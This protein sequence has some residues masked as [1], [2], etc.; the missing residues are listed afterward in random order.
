MAA[1]KDLLPF[2]E[3]NAAIQDYIPD[4]AI[5]DTKFFNLY[6]VYQHALTYTLNNDERKLFRHYLNL[7]MWAQVSRYALKGL[8]RKPQK[9]L[10][11]T[12]IFDD[13]RKGNSQAGASPSRFFSKTLALAEREKLSL[14]Q[15]V[16]GDAKN[17]DL[18]LTD[19][20]SSGNLALDQLEV[21][22]LSEINR[23]AKEA[24]AI[25][26]QGFQEYLNAA[27]QLFFE[28]FHQY[29]AAFKGQ[30]IDRLFLIC[31][32]HNE[33][34]IA[35]CKI[36]G[37][38]VIEYQHGLI[39]KN[40]LYYVYPESII[41]HRERCLFPDKIVVF[42]P[43]WRD[44]LCLGNEFSPEQVIVG[45]NYS[46]APDLKPKSARH[47]KEKAILIGAQKNMADTYVAYIS[48]LQKRLAE[49]HPEWKLLV[50][51]HPSEPEV[52]KY[53]QFAQ[54]TNCE[55]HGKN[56]VLDVL[57]ERS[58]IQISIYSTT[59]YDAIG[60]DVLNLSLQN[61]SSSSDYAAEMVANK[62][63]FPLQF[64]DDP[65]ERY[66][67]L[68][69]RMGELLERDDLYAPF[70]ADVIAALINSTDPS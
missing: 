52:E 40:D 14:I 46:L 66:F 19:L 3:L 47:P 26:L 38:E 20:G 53:D 69:P 68:Q 67:E 35:A 32:Y 18:T 10:Q 58:L 33:S 29:Y 39:A 50:K 37:I 15:K 36:L 1:N 21:E 28:L 8:R 41:P 22:V 61:Y 55:L 51:L 34:L 44:L 59:L 49:S 70:R 23:L 60:L 65:V 6:K 64:D 31:H 13:G 30:R 43:F 2:S 25:K 42:G 5:A 54:A 9:K 17:F 27:L 24:A 62:V 12:L 45:G 7:P 48:S 11:P 4:P 63:A 57:L 16:D 56:S